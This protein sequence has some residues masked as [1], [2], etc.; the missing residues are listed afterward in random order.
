MD[1]N[2]KHIATNETDK[3]AIDEKLASDWRFKKGLHVGNQQ[4]YEKGLEHGRQ[5]A[6][7]EARQGKLNTWDIYSAQDIKSTRSKLI[8]QIFRTIRKLRGVYNL[9]AGADIIITDIKD[10]IQGL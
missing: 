4:G 5:Q 6:I 7:R 8:A 9:P 1:K 3:P 2:L 10:E